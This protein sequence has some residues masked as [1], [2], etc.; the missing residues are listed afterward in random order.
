MYQDEHDTDGWATERGDYGPL[1]GLLDA[2]STLDWITPAYGALRG[3]TVLAVW[4]EDYVWAQRKLD[5]AG[6]S[7]WAWQIIDGDLYFNVPDED[8]VRACRVL[9]LPPPERIGSTR[10]RLYTVLAVLGVVGLLFFM[11]QLLTAGGVMQ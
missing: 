10:L 2:A 11:F 5:E 3:G 7:H 9:G 4:R 8:A 1:D 6:I